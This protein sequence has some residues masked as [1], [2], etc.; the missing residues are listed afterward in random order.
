MPLLVHYLVKHFKYNKLGMS[1]LAS[2]ANRK[3]FHF[4]HHPSILNN[5]PRLSFR[6]YHNP[7]KKGF[8]QIYN[9][10]KTKFHNMHSELDRIMHPHPPPPP[11]PPQKTY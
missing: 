3:N 7:L 8:C 2:S 6:V 9:L 10:V 4:D 11:T 1:T 5:V